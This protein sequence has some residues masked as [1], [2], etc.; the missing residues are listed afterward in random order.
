MGSLKVLP[1]TLAANG[2]VAELVKILR[3]MGLRARRANWTAALSIG[4]F[5]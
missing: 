1:R 5:G 3:R 2:F 4:A